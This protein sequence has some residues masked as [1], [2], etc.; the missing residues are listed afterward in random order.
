MCSEA[1]TK[2]KRWKFC[3]TQTLNTVTD[4][5]Y[6]VHHRYLILKSEQTLMVSALTTCLVLFHCDS[7]LTMAIVDLFLT[8]FS[9]LQSI[10]LYICIHGP[11][12]P[13]SSLCIYSCYMWKK[14]SVWNIFHALLYSVHEYENFWSNIYYTKIL[15]Q[16]ISKLQ[17]THNPLTTVE[18][19]K[20]LS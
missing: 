19:M 4:M 13:T 1:S 11:S 9:W 10:C 20:N 18:S 15:T 3:Y 17:C 14:F 5:Q 2:T 7:I 6:I 8:S 12:K 16:K